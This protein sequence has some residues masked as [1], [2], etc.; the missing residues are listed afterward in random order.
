MFLLFRIHGIELP[1]TT[2]RRR[3][4]RSFVGEKRDLRDVNDGYVS[5]SC[6]KYVLFFVELLTCHLL[7]RRCVEEKVSF[8]SSLFY[9]TLTFFF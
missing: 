2:K 3:F 4:R 8:F 5:T 6:F 7:P 9:F 1:V